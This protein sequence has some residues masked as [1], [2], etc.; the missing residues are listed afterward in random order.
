MEKKLERSHSKIVSHLNRVNSKKQSNEKPKS[1]FDH[2]QETQKKLA[3]SRLGKITPAILHEPNQKQSKEERKDSLSKIPQADL[4]KLLNQHDFDSIRELFL[5]SRD[6]LPLAVLSELLIIKVEKTSEVTQFIPKKAKKE[7]KKEVQKT[8]LQEHFFYRLNLFAAKMEENDPQH[9][10]LINVIGEIAQA[11]PNICIDEETSSGYLNLETCLT[12]T[13]KYHI[14]EAAAFYGD[15]ALLQLHKQLGLIEDPQIYKLFIIAA[16]ANQQKVAE[17]LIKKCGFDVHKKLT[18]QQGATDPTEIYPISAAVFNGADSHFLY[19]L[20]HE[21][22][23]NVLK[24]LTHL[25][26]ADQITYINYFNHTNFNFSAHVAEQLAHA[27]HHVAFLEQISSLLQ[28]SILKEEEAPNTQPLE[29]LEGD[30]SDTDTSSTTNNNSESSSSSSVVSTVSF[31][32][33]KRPLEK[34]T[35]TESEQSNSL[36]F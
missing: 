8:V 4:L 32:S 29:D 21:R 12:N 9:Q 2:S 27:K 3:L 36:T 28:P 11:Y 19:Y 5:Y 13:N 10:Q 20:I 17:F 7:T 6:T 1:K 24:P 31:I 16:K 25:S 22:H 30:K 23:I 18:Q 14:T 15:I 35:E 26:K 33:R 34:E